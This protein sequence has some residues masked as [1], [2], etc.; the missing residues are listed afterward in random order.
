MVNPEP[1]AR[2][3]YPIE[4]RDAKFLRAPGRGNAQAHGEVAD[5][6]QD[7]LKDLNGSI[8]SVGEMK[9]PQWFGMRGTGSMRFVGRFAEMWQ[10]HSE[11]H[12][13]NVALI[14]GVPEG[15]SDIAHVRGL[16]G[17][18]KSLLAEEYALRFG[19]GF[20]GGIFWLRAY[21]HDDVKGALGDEEREAE[22]QRQIADF[23]MAL[24]VE[25][26]R[27]RSEEIE[28]ALADKIGD[29]KMACLWVV[30]DLPSAMPTDKL[31]RWFAPHPLSKTLI[32]SRSRE[33]SALPGCIHL[34]VL[35]L[36]DGYELLTWRRQP[37]GESE[38][39]AAHAI[40]KSLGGHALAIDV[41]AAA[42]SAA[43]GLESYASFQAELGLENKD[44]LELA[45]FLADELPNGHEKNVSQTL[46]ST[47]WKIQ[48]VSFL[49]WRPCW[50][51]HRFHRHWRRKS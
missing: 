3:I 18:G 29:R 51:S 50:P 44:A 13:T 14:T 35:S 23:A 8:G 36:E 28:V 22:R 34:D 31:R 16:G 1:D 39:A 2:H 6:I 9:V 12:K 37:R 15:G 38:V 17:I 24:G 49:D 40:V 25:T 10:V 11:L 7:Y 26:A 48:H 4:L 33:H 42:L 45:A 19:A 30:D 20:P 43:E 21:G 5:R 27:M 47:G 46:L 41:V 32:T